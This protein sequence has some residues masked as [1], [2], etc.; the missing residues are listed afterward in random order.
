MILNKQYIVFDDPSVHINGVE[1]GDILV[2]IKLT[3]CGLGVLGLLV[4]GKE[5]LLPDDYWC[6]LLVEESEEYLTELNEQSIK[7][8][9][10]TLQEQ[11]N[12]IMNKV[13]RLDIMLATKDYEF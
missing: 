8:V 7:E 11:S 3:L 6:H 1:I 10:N 2:A 4:N 13:I 9:T 12:Q 5:I